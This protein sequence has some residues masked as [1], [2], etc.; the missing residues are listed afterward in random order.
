M[1][2]EAERD[3]IIKSILVS[4]Q[5]A[6][7]EQILAYLEKNTAEIADDSIRQALMIAALT[8]AMPKAVHEEAADEHFGSWFLAAESAICLLFFIG[9]IWLNC[10]W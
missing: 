9:F 3:V 6:L 5:T 10:R 7:R 2:T 8:E 4:D 1:N